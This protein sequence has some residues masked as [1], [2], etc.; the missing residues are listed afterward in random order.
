MNLYID[1]HGRKDN[2]NEKLKKLLDDYYG[3]CRNDDY[4][5]EIINFITDQSDYIAEIIEEAQQ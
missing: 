4:K 3:D 1:K 5:E 2:M